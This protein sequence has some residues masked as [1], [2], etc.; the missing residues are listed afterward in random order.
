MCDSQSHT[1]CVLQVKKQRGNFTFPMKWL[2]RTASASA[3][4]AATGR[5]RLGNNNGWQRQHP[6]QHGA[7][8]DNLL[9]CAEMKALQTDA[10]HQTIQF[11][12]THRLNSNGL[13]SIPLIPQF[14][15]PFHTRRNLLNYSALVQELFIWIDYWKL[16]TNYWGYNSTMLLKSII[17]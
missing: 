14:S 4:P 8:P 17:A 15:P 13:V 9:A 7:Y 5:E 10:V 16:L 3:P 12:E 1:I 2:N 11:R 6:P